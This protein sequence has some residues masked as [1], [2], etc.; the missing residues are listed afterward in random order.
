MV[1]VDD[2][3]Q[4]FIIVPA[5]LSIIN[6]FSSCEMDA[7]VSGELAPNTRNVTSHATLSRPKQTKMS[8]QAQAS[9]MAGDTSSARIVPWW[10]PGK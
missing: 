5:R 4:V 8:C 10:Q 7:W 1:V 3:A 9:M 2:E 6:C